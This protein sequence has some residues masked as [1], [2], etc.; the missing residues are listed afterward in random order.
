MNLDAFKTG[1]P[2]VYA[3]IPATDYHAL[4]AV[5]ASRLK[6]LRRSAAHC[7]WEIENPKETD[8]MLIGEAAHLAVLQPNLL[9]D[10]FL[11]APDVD[12]RT[13]A[14]KEAWEAAQ[15]FG[16]TLLKA[17]QWV[18]VCGMAA[19]VRAHPAA[20]KLLADEGPVELSILWTDPATGLLCK[21][22]LDKHVTKYRTVFDL[23]TTTDASPDA[24]AEGVYR[25][26]YHLQGAHYLY[27]CERVGID[28]DIFGI[29]AVEKDP[30]HCVAVYQL[31]HDAILAGEMERERL[32]GFYAACKA[33][34]MW[35]GYPEKPVELGLKSYH[36]SKIFNAA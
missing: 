5:S 3:D 2:G 24:F 19:A 16:A 10:R 30:P 27:G 29:V 7:C 9:T 6:S 13:K 28:A 21:A 12:R 34:G 1:T 15:S 14:G 35:P 25:F 36:Q 31:N 33:S 23:K 22:R 26:G 17:D 18:C 11:P 8:A 20:R 32:M 4:D